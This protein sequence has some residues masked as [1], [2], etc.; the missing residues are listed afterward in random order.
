[1]AIVNR[2]DWWVPD[3]DRKALS[4]VLSEVSDLD[5]A[6]K[7]VT[8]THCALQAGGNVGIW[9]IAMTELFDHVYTWEPDQEN[10]LALC[11]N[12]VRRVR[13]CIEGRRLIAL[14]FAL[15]SDHDICDVEVYE[16][17]NIGAHQTIFGTG[18]VLVV[19]MDDVM[20]AGDLDEG[21]GL[22]QLD[23]EGHE[24]E[25]LL[26]ARRII[27]KHHPVV[28]LELKGL[29]TR[30]GYPD[31]ATYALMESWG[32]SVAERIHRDVI[33]VWNKP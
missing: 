10:Y 3:S 2:S 12:V 30:F 11:A 5:V 20:Y 9:P 33:F 19:T 21:V 32:Y 24:H 15:G 23:I 26:G 4:I 16:P 29:G 27:E 6:M 13:G 17:G 25:A 8:N 22:I 31:L 1:M 14:P 7:Y 18:D 28:M